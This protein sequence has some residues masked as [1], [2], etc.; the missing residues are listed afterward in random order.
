MSTREQSS[1]ATP[2]IDYDK[3][4]NERAQ[5]VFNVMQT[6]S[7]EEDMKRLREAFEFARQ[8]HSAQKRKSGEPYILHPIAVADIAASEINLDVNSVIA[9]F[10]HDVVEDTNHSIEEIQDKFGE[11]VAFLVRVLT[12]QKKEKYEMTKQLD[13]FKQML[14]SVQYDIRALLVKLSDRLHNMRTLSSMRTDKQMK[15]AGETDY[16]YA[17]LATRLGLYDVKT[18]LENL[19]LRFRCPQEYAELENRIREDQNANKEKLKIFIDE[20]SILLA[21]NGIKARVFYDYRRP[22]SLWRKMHKYGDDFDHLKYRHFVEIVFKEEE[23]QSE[24][25]SVLRIYSLLT[26]RF[27]EKPGGISNYI[28]SPKE[29]GYQSFHLK[30]LA[31]Y[32]RWEEVHICSERMV[33]NSKYGCLS[34]RSEGN[35]RRW[36]NKFRGVLKDI[37]Q[38][39]QDGTN[40]IENVVASFYNDDI[41]TFTPE[42]KPVIMRQKATPVDF[43]Y[44]IHSELGRHAKYCRINGRLAS[45]KQPLH[46]GDIVEIFTDPD[47]HPEADWIDHCVSYK[48]R[49]AITSYL[50]KQPKP[51]FGRCDHCHPIPGEEVIGFKNPDGSITVHKR[52]CSVA[53]RLA[54]QMGDN[55]VA[56]N[57]QANAT[58]YPVEL[59]ITC[60]DRPHMII[61]IMDCISNKLKL[62]VE[63]LNTS[64]TDSI[65]LLKIRLGVHDYTEIQTITAAIKAI[66]DVEEVRAITL[67]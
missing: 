21:S 38:H 17:P 26:D 49:R 22:Y 57:Y 20:I 12:K 7:S 3:I 39:G 53:I 32:G 9:A 13:N 5:H 48:A 59:L 64:T 28:D 23:G 1:A 15:I 63:S 31:D 40:F 58:V 52:D 37:A 18:E 54:S 55:I 62:S 6:R 30:L 27:K 46:R 35:I 67:N 34:D 44:E 51:E 43:A 47:C 61:D 4:V 36:I 16:F 50:A 56:V 41:M 8:A 10:L 45:I 29:N 60:I 25:A 14:N 42:G 19:S 66:P 24:K 2:L 65:V 33:R 11:D